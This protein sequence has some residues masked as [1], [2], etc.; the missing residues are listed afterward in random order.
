MRTNNRLLT[1]TL[2]GETT[3]KEYDALGRVTAIIRPLGNNRTMGYDLLGRLST[4][5]DDPDKSKLVTRYEYDANDNLRFQLDPRGNKV[6]YVY[7]KLNRKTKHIQY[8]EGGNLTVSYDYDSEGN[9]I[10]MLDAKSQSFS[11]TYDALNRQTLASYPVAET[12]Y[13]TIRSIDT[14][15]DPNNN[16]TKI[17]ETKTQ[18]DGTII[19]DVTDNE[20]DSFDRVTATTQRGLAI[21]YDYDANGNRTKVESPSGTTNYTFDGRNRLKTAVVGSNTTTYYYTP[22]GKQARISYPNGTETIYT[23]YSTNRVKNVSNTNGETAFSSYSYLYDANGNRTEQVEL[24]N[25]TT[26]T[27]TYSYNSL[28][29]MTGYTITGEAFTSET[30]YTFEGYNRK[31]E[32]ISENSTITKNRTYTYDETDWLTSIEDDADPAKTQIISYAYDL[33]GNTIVKSDS[34]QPEQD[35]TFTY[36][37]RNQL[38]QT[39]RGP[40]ISQQ[41]LGQY[42][43]NAQGLRVRHLSSERGDIDYFYDDNAVLEE[44]RSSD[45]TLLAHYRYAHR[46]LSLT[47]DTGNQYY[48]YDA[49]GS[50]V[51]LTT[52]QGTVQVSYQLDPWGHIRHQ[53][54][55]TLNR[56]I[57]TGQEHDENTGLIYFGAR[58][59]DPDTARFIN[60]DSYLGEPGTPPSLH[61][62]LYAYSNPTVWV[63]LHGYRA[64]IP[65]E[66]AEIAL[67]EEASAGYQESYEAKGAFGKFWSNIWH[68]T[69]YSKW[70]VLE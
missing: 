36:D 21:S 46:L 37:S 63:D 27:T 58:Y 31:T 44:H 10:A 26:E 15:Y 64:A 51:N 33:N 49:L 54:G 70:K 2:A 12:P 18:T 23:Y 24:Q 39:T 9:L 50:T 19:T 29:Q 38:V 60:Q 57:F 3:T 14:E 53:S 65:E 43:Y 4:V 40:P 1:T 5:Q 28:D 35:I 13:L 62:Y 67:W 30:L 59:Y 16:V 41:L 68:G 25:G 69:D 61:R 47:S 17:S 7:D 11:Y 6:E 8:K 55:T 56:Q 42:D 20:Y 48:H 22:D 66:E 45:N 52:D 34:L 32:T